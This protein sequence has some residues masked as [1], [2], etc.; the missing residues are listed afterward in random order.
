MTERA[1]H[2]LNESVGPDLGPRWRVGTRWTG[3]LDDATIAQVESRY[4]VRFPPEHRLFL[5][6]LHST[7]PGRSGYT[8]DV[9]DH[10]VHYAAGGFYDWLGDERQIRTAMSN[11]ETTM[12]E[13]PFDDQDWQTT[14]VGRNTKPS[15]LPIL[16]HRYVVADA[17][18]W[19]LSI[20]DKD[21]IIY[22]YGMRD[23]LLHE[24]ADLLPVDSRA[25][26]EQ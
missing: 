13:L 20:M 1:W 14:W 8:Y 25:T 9:H 2:V 18:Q 16:G 11:V 7:T 5:Q 23:Y 3:A 6:T 4:H 12:R 26:T 19:V 17:D 15:L 24:L 22:G 21:A 10:P